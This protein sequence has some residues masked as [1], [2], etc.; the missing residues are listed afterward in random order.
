MVEPIP[1]DPEGKA[2]LATVPKRFNPAM[3]KV[4][5]I[6]FIFGLIQIPLY[7]ILGTMQDRQTYNE[8]YARE[9]AGWG[10]GEQTIVGPVLT[11]P[12]HY[13]AVEEAKPNTTK[14]D[15]GY[16]HFFP[17]SL[18]VSGNLVPEIRDG[19]KFKN[20]LYSTALEFKGKFDTSQIS[21]KKIKDSDVMWRDAVPN[22]WSFRSAR[23]SQGD[24]RPL[25]RRPLHLRS[26]NKWRHDVRFRAK[27]VVER[28]ETISDLSVFSDTAIER[29]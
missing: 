2:P 3:V 1:T 18:E 22:S 11:V 20:I 19:G 25:E 4:F 14:S 10:A 9:F 5:L 7:L 16:L 26:W 6:A 17:E 23:Y 12:Y 24:D 8:Q 27:C 21:H 28:I 29:K 13:Q 15:T